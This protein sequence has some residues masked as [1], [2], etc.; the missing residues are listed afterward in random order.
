MPG[1]ELYDEINE[2][3]LESLI[4]LGLAGALAA[5]VFYRQQR[6]QNHQRA[7]VAN[8]PGGGTE[9]AQGLVNADDVDRP[10]PEPDGGLFPPHDDPN[11]DAWRVGGVGHLVYTSVM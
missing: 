4:I 3:V 5:L 10:Q 6:Q 7:G 11:F 1:D 2:S 8:Q 9:G